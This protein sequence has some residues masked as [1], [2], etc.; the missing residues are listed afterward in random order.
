[1]LAVSGMVSLFFNN[2]QFV[3]KRE[4]R[5]KNA[6]KSKITRE[7]VSAARGFPVIFL[8]KEKKRKKI[9]HRKYLFTLLTAPRSADP[10]CRG[11]AKVAGER[12]GAVGRASTQALPRVGGQRGVSPPRR[13]GA[14]L[15]LHGSLQGGTA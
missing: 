15:G 12:G 3:N 10:K 9:V 4:R 1:M 11:R 8:V 6:C 7:A 14:L 2:R 13:V 5:K